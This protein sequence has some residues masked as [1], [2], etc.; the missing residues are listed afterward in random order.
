MVYELKD[1]EKAALL[2]E[3]WQ[4]T[5][6]WSCLRRVMGK[7]YTDSLEQPS[8]AMAFLADFCFFAGK[9]DA[10]LVR[11]WSGMGGLD[12]VSVNAAGSR[13]PEEALEGMHG[14]M[15]EAPEEVHRKPEEAPDEM[16]C[17]ARI[18]SP[19][20]FP[21]REIIM[22]P[23]NRAWG[24][25]IEKCYKD[26]AKKSVRYAIKKEPDIF[27]REKLQAAVSS[28]PDGYTL[29]MIDETLY[30]QC[31]QDPWCW[32][33]VGNFTDYA[34]YQRF[35]LGAAI[36]KDGEL[37]SGASS[38]TGYGEGIEIQIDTREAYRRKGLAYICGA[39]LILECLDRGWY[40]SWD[41]QNLWSAALAEKLGYHFDRE[42][43]AY[44]VYK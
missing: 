7:I 8:S 42:Y 15:E 12:A 31:L 26:K 24:E 38:Y 29:K 16:R 20:R 25:L 18:G 35:G 19:E 21:S 41:A 9:P 10:E 11:Y 43:T 14:K 33:W 34:M 6:I 36:F 13:K 37:V 32:D 22:V 40:P 17:D 30:M 23:R 28:L 27:D 5:M 44:E 3:G 39:K 1:T 2:F 4:E